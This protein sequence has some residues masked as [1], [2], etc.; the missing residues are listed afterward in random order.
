MYI[1][2]KNDMPLFIEKTTIVNIKM[3]RFIEDHKT[4]YQVMEPRH[5]LHIKTEPR[6]LLHIM[7]IMRKEEV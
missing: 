7:T 4:S 5:L 1:I 6:H 2:I 3:T